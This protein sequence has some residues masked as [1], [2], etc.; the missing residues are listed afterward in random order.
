MCRSERESTDTTHLDMASLLLL[1][2]L[3]L[4][5]TRTKAIDL[6]FCNLIYDDALVIFTEIQIYHQFLFSV[7]TILLLWQHTGLLG[8]KCLKIPF[9]LCLNSHP[10]ATFTQ[11]SHIP[12]P[13]AGW[14]VG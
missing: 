11:M 8:K 4:K 6:E 14:I 2:W 7:E 3:L 1:W 13:F 5:L 12:F 10:F 9:A